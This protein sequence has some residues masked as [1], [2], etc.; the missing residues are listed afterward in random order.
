MSYEGHWID[1]FILSISR[2]MDNAAY[3]YIGV[4]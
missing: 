1:L 3:H 2:D 4:N